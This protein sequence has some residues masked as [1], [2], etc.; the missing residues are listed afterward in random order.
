MIESFLTCIHEDGYSSISSN[1]I[2]MASGFITRLP[3]VDPGG[4]SGASNFQSPV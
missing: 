1:D 2:I 3:L 4:A